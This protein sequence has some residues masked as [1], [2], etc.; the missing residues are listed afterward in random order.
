MSMSAA[1]VLVYLITLFLEGGQL[2][3]CQTEEYLEDFFKVYCVPIFVCLAIVSARKVLKCQ[4]VSAV[5]HL[6]LT[7][8][9]LF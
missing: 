8:L 1:T 5:L 4:S 9:I 7:I 3:S 6:M 2:S